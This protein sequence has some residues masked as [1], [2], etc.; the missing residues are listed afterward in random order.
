M[1]AGVV[2]PIAVHAHARGALAQ[3]G[4]VLQGQR[5][6][7]LAADDADHVLH[8]LL[9]VVLHPVGFRAAFAPLTLERSQ[10]GAG[11]GIDLVL[12]DPA[13]A[14]ILDEARG[15]RAGALAEDQQVRKRVPAQPVRPVQSGGALSCRE[16]ARNARHLRLRVDAH[17][18]HDVVRGWSDLHRLPGDVDVREL[19]EL[20][21]HARQLLADDRL[22]VRQPPLDPGDVEKDA[23]VRAPAAL[24]D[25][26][27]D[28][29]RD[30][31][32]GEE[33]RG[34]ARALVALGVAPPFLLVV[35]GLAAIVLRDG[36]EEEAPAFL[37]EQHPALAADALGDEDALHAGR[38]DH[39][40]GMELDELHVD[41][42]G[43]RIV[44]ERLAVARVLPAV[45]GDPVGLSDPAGGEHDRARAKEVEQPFLAIVRQGAGDSLRVLEQ[46][47]HRVLHVDVDALVD[48]VVLEGADHLQP[49]AIPHVRQ[50]RVAVPAKVA[51]EDPPVP[52]AIEERSP[53]LQL[54]HA[55]GRLPGVQLRHPPVVDVLAAP[56]GVREMHLPAVALVDVRE[57][58]RDAAL[59]HHRVRLAEQRLAHQ[60]D[61]D[62][63][64]G[65]F[66]GRAQPGA[67][68]ADH[69]DIV[70]VR[71][72]LGRQ[73]ILQSRI[74]PI[75][76]R[77][78]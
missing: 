8:H 54:A 19:E 14:T 77:R 45:A 20:V 28:A 3:L 64:G 62:L 17:S 70:L 25:L 59:G 26:A 35:G 10:R 29:A 9:Q 44:R 73:T 58:R 1:P 18:A 27:H 37:V 78:T 61:G 39:P 52:G 75:E 21:I 36:V 4:Q 6:L 50:P 13:R 55:S 66:D 5:H 76:Q 12:V 74:T 48:A 30:V 11:G 53:G 22:G 34:P 56:H 47:D 16:E 65:S 46:R 38:P 41:Q 63:G 40:G 23:A 60:A 42:L 72:H 67:P 15:V 68:G 24:A 51:L 33:L 71:L 2:G 7:A 32:A 49:G 57:R 43:A 31:V 69:Q